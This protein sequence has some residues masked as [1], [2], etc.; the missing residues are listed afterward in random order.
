M[1]EAWTDAIDSEASYD[2]YGEGAYDSEAYGEGAYDSEA[3]GEAYG[4]A[5]G[6][7]FG[8]ESR[9]D[10]RRR[11]RQRRI[12]QERQR[13][14]QAQMRLP[15]RAPSQ[16]RPA[17]PAGPSPRQTI[18][19]VRD[20]DLDTKVG[21]DSLRRA[22]EESNRRAARATWAAVA[23]TAV[24]QGLASFDTDAQNHPYVAAGVRFAPL[25]FL[26]PEKKR[27]GVEG[28]V[29]DPRVIGGAAILGIALFGNYHKKEQGANTVTIADPGTITPSGYGTLNAAAFDHSGAPLTP[30]PT[31]T[32][33]SNSSYLTFSGTT[34]GAY[35]TTA[36]AQGNVLVTA[37]GGGGIG[38]KWVT[39]DTG[40]I[41][42]A[43]A[44]GSGPAP[45]P[46]A[47]APAAGSGPAPA[48][49]APAPA[50]PAPAAPAPAAGP[51]TS[52]TQPNP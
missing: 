43:P 25:L 38:S 7:G 29:T 33:T 2:A 44:A 22:L 45:A 11:E 21:L 19:A 1:S 37:Q 47:P 35:T 34:P 49:A 27:G 18:A 36:D 32:W 23:S 6:E 48:P 26:S 24:D 40:I 4:D 50:A 10:R 17:R 46:A 42:S 20:L 30:Q 31:F 14:R 12:L 41:I 52:P 13:Q 8:E 5:S 15:R 39:I 51:V 28:I 16:P 9:A 3:Y